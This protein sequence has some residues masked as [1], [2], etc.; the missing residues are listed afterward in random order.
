MNPN[1]NPR[2]FPQPM[3]QGQQMMIPQGQMMPQGQ[4]MNAGQGHFGGQNQG[5]MAM[6]P[7]GFNTNV[8]IELKGKKLPKKISLLHRI[9]ITCL[10]NIKIKN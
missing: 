3:Q 8:S 2:G 1:F 6:R 7:P 4:F 10:T 5:Q 9:K